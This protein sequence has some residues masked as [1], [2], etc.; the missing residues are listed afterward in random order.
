MA[1][2]LHEMPTR[3]VTLLIVIVRAQ[4][5]Y[6]A[7]GDD[8]NEVAVL[9]NIAYATLMN[10]ALRETYQSDVSPSQPSTDSATR[11]CLTRR[12]RG[13]T[14]LCCTLFN[15]RTAVLKEH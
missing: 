1:L 10:D 15:P 11:I 4:R 3:C 5:L 14:D 9:L 6:I 12:Q 2:V 8:A 13:L 7:A